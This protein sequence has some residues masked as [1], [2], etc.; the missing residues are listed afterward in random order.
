[1]AKMYVHYGCGL[2]A[3]KGWVNFDASVTL[4][5]EKTP[6]V[7]KLYTR[8]ASRFEPNV[9]SGD[10]VKGL[11]IADGACRGVYASH[12]LEHLPLDDFHRA[13]ENTHRML[14]ENG[15]FR[16]VVP[17]LE[18]AAREYVKRLENKEPTANEFFLDETRLGCRTREHG[19]GARLQ[20]VLSTS[21]HYWMW[22]ELSLADALRTHGF[23]NIR[24]CY[25]GDSPDPMFR[26][27]EAA[28][29]FDRAVGMEGIR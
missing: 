27:V 22:D 5:F 10:I 29:R 15:V 17:D 24:R 3:P 13:L 1:M 7:G 14:A 2:T 11:P 23:R 20:E 26:F 6:I 12:V 28:D 21:R 9:R 19:L 18:W 25:F 4:K 16:L 8:N